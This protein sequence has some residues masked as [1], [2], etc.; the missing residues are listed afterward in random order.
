MTFPAEALAH[1]SERDVRP[2]G[3]FVVDGSWFFRVKGTLASETYQGYLRLSG[4]AAGAIS[5]SRG[6]P[7]TALANT[8]AW[9]PIIPSLEGER[10]GPRTGAI[11]LSELGP[12]IWGA[13]GDHYVPYLLDGTPAVALL[14]RFEEGPAF[15][16][17]SAE[18]LRSGDAQSLGTLFAL[19]LRTLE[20]RSD[21]VS[22]L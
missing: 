17:W 2:G 6:D 7:V 15:T 9:R 12:V 14:Q 13:I 8:Y 4:P 11:V 19:P 18:L 3:L 20:S 10:G 22:A 21:G 16:S 1:L 5:P